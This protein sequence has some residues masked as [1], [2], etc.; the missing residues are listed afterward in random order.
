MNV[1]IAKLRGESEYKSLLEYTSIVQTAADHI[2]ILN[3]FSKTLDDSDTIN[4]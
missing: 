4:K 3:I 2:E 1:I